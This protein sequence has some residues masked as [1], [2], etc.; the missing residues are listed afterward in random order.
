MPV[1]DALFAAMLPRA[2]GVLAERVRLEQPIDLDEVV[3]Q[4]LAEFRTIIELDGYGS[5]LAARIKAAL[6]KRL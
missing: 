5:G 2:E 1:A 4:V 6:Q 3:E